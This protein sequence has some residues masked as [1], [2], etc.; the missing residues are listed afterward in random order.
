LSLQ[1]NESGAEGLVS[2]HKERE[3]GFASFSCSELMR[4][5]EMRL[6]SELLSSHM[7]R[8]RSV[9]WQRI[10]KTLETMHPI[11]VRKYARVI[12]SIILFIFY[13]L[14]SGVDSTGL[15]TVGRR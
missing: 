13:F 11:A 6:E 9:A 2:G 7:G 3:I 14:L 5:S 4:Q 15:L 1:A 12:V 8:S 10:I